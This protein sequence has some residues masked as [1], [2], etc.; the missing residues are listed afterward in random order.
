M[1]VTQWEHEPS[2]FLAVAA[3]ERNAKPFHF[4]TSKLIGLKKA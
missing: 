1:K 3:K 2:V 4:N